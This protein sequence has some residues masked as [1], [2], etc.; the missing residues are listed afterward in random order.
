MWHEGR[1]FVFNLF[2]S[3]DL[4]LRCK[5]QK[6]ETKL[7]IRFLEDLSIDIRLIQSIKSI[8]VVG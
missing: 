4:N 6:P 7:L 3:I 5:R 1:A 8:T 2:F